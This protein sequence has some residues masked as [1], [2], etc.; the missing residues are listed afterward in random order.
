[1]GISTDELVRQNGRFAAAGAFAGLPFPTNQ[2][3]RVVGC[4]SGGRVTPATLRS[5]ALPGR[6][7]QGQPLID[8]VRP[9]K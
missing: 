2:T 8:I 9:A 5:W 4:N 7:S 6:L 3:P 1:M